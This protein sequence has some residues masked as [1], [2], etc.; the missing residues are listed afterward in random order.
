VDGREGEY[1]PA[2]LEAMSCDD[3]Q[4]LLT[5][6]ETEEAGLG[7]VVS[8]P[9]WYFALTIS[10]KEHKNYQ[11][12]SR[13]NLAFSGGG[14]AQGTVVRTELS[15]DG[16]AM[17][18]VIR[19]DTVTEDTVSRRAATVRLSS[20]NYTGVRFD[21]EYLRIVDGVKGVYVD[22][23]YSVKFKTVDIIY[24]GDTYYLSRLN[25]TGEEQLNIF[26]KLIASKTELYDG[27]PLSDL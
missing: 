12:G 17:M 24:E 3:L 5:A 23:G 14:T 26:D 9:E 2:R 25:Y 19:G 13:V 7:K 16:S 20:E 11:L 15:D 4:T 6:G 1:T 8:G 18:L 27:M 22:N 10:S 21:K